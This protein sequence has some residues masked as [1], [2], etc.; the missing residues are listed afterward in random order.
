M[1]NPS[2]VI[3]MHVQD[4][5]NLGGSNKA[6]LPSVD[7]NGNI[8]WTLSEST[9]PPA[10][11]NIKGAPGADGQ[12]GTDGTDG[13]GIASI[14]KTSTSGKVDTYT[15]T[16]T[17]GNTTTFTVTNGMGVKSVDINGN[18]HLIVT[19]DDNTTHDAGEIVG[20]GGSSD[21]DALPS[22][23]VTEYDDT[24]H[25][26]QQLALASANSFAFGFTSDLHFCTEDS[27]FSDTDKDKL[28]SGIKRM[29]K[30]FG[31]F[32]R[33]FPLATT[34]IGGD[35]AYFYDNNDKQNDIDNIMEINEWMS[36]FD[37]NKIVFR[38]N[39]E[40][41]YSGDSE[42]VGLDFDEFYDICSKKY[43]AGKIEKIS[44]TIYCQVDDVD[45]VCFIY[46]NALY[47]PIVTNAFK[48]EIR[49]AMA[50]NTN[51]Y[52][53]IISTHY[54]IQ[55]TQEGQNVYI[56][57]GCKNVID[58][59]KTE[60][61]S[62]I[63]WIAGHAHS[64]WHDV[65]NNTLIMTTEAA[66]FKS[67][68]I[69]ESGQTYTKTL[70][71]ATE[72]AFSIYT[73]DKESGKLYCTR[74]GAGDDRVYHYN[75]Y[76]GAIGSATDYAYS[77]TQNLTGVTSDFSKTGTDANATIELTPTTP[78]DTIT[79]LVT[80]G[81][82]DVTSTAW[83]SSTNTVTISNANG[84][85]V[86]T[87]TSAQP[88][89]VLFDFEHATDVIE[90]KVGTATVTTS[91]NN[92]SATITKGGG[93]IM[94]EYGSSSQTITTN[95][96]LK[97]ICDS[98]EL[99]EIPTEFTPA[100]CQITIRDGENTQIGTQAVPNSS[101]SLSDLLSQMANG[102]VILSLSGKASLVEWLM[103]ASKIQ[104]SFRIA[105]NNGATV[106]PAVTLAIN[107]FKVELV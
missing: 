27:Q 54:G 25:T 94:A 20:G 81:G 105:T 38:G 22:F 45:E 53:Y 74:F 35:F 32:T 3:K 101:T 79:A 62:I 64:D 82:V 17:N 73:V 29:M 46:I 58:F 4:V 91:G 26:V 89:I 36:K 103:T 34:I 63:A 41:K 57:D 33:Q 72:S 14:A 12:D 65:W 106:S 102:G 44:K 2:N 15:I 85:I 9:T 60:G 104:I 47:D 97:F 76:S 100:Y 86:I 93:G 52:P 16:L 70:N 7:A 21:P 42:S 31:K 13:V 83:D 96:S 23:Y 6:W 69:S 18:N 43:V 39:H 71:T 80:M 55:N 10:T 59:V 84:N 90:S 78:G 37:G 24:I 67:N 75:D 98:Y 61:G 51:S 40:Y 56:A 49:A 88:T 87:A 50:K 30:A 95:N 5:V 68:K 1:L 11:Q 19:Y 92:A 8:S 28:R 107:N 66:G 48:A 77:I 99:S